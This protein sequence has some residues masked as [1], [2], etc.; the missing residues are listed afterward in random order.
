[1]LSTFAIIQDFSWWF[2]E[3]LGQHQ[4]QLDAGLREISHHY[5]NYT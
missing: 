3:S 5:R 4:A 2:E 1:M